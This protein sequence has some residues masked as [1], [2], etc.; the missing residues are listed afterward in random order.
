MAFSL[1]IADGQIIHGFV[2]EEDDVLLA[3]IGADEAAGKTYFAVASLSPY[4]DGCPE[5][6]FFIIERDVETEAERTFWSGIDCKGIFSPEDKAAIRQLICFMTDDL[7]RSVRPMRVYRCTYDV[8]PPERAMEKHHI[9][10]HVFLQ[11][12]YTVTKSDSWH[13]KRVW[14]AELI[15]TDSD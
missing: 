5:Y 2:D 15:G 10:S 6:S 11:C 12:G 13:G 4:E 3:Y 14:W 8:R 1:D 9:I 7:L